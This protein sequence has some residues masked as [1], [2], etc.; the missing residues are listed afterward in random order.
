MMSI[1]ANKFL[2]FAKKQLLNKCK[3]E[4]LKL[5][6]VLPLAKALHAR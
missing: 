4:S 1:S 5:F 2:L 3:Y 6:Q